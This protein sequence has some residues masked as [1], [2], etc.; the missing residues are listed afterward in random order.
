M[1][2]PRHLYKTAQFSIPAESALRELRSAKKI[3]KEKLQASDSADSAEAK[4]ARRRTSRKKASALAL[5]AA[6]ELVCLRHFLRGLV[7]EGLGAIRHEMCFLESAVCKTLFLVPQTG[8]PVRGSYS[9]E[10]GA[11]SGRMIGRLSPGLFSCKRHSGFSECFGPPD[12]AL[13]SQLSSTTLWIL[14]LRDFRL[15]SHLSPLVSQYRVDA[16]SRMISHLSPTTLWILHALPP[17]DFRL[18]SLCTLS[19]FLH[20]SSTCPSI[21]SG[22]LGALVRTISHLSPTCL[23]LSP[24]CLPVV[25]C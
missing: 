18:V 20:L 24:P 23:R 4:G 25:S 2:L 11:C 17:H 1:T 14:C 16:L 19:T 8:L 12:F 6:C 10:R 21:H 15:V 22:C 7:K 9:F 5:K 13:V 3:Q